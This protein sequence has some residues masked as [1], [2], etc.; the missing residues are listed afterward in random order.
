MPGGMSP[1]AS[2]SGQAF[3]VRAC[4]AARCQA[5]VMFEWWLLPAFRHVE[6]EQAPPAPSTTRRLPGSQKANGQGFGVALRWLW[7][8]LAGLRP[9]AVERRNRGHSWQASSCAR[10]NPRGGGLFQPPPIMCQTCRPCANE[11]CYGQENA[12]K[13]A[14][15]NQALALAG[16]NRGLALPKVSHGPARSRSVG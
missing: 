2:N 3:M 13:T 4:L 1:C 9:S 8:A 6:V 5:R 14:R 16:A 12:G 7:V 15:T 11:I 10:K